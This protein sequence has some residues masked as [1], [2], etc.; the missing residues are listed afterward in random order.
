MPKLKQIPGG[1]TY[2]I[3]YLTLLFVLPIVAT[4][5]AVHYGYVTPDVT[6]TATVDLTTPLDWLAKG[7]V[8][9]FLLWTALQIVRVTGVGFW[10]RVADV[11][12]EIADNYQR[13]R[14]ETIQSAADA[15]EEATDQTDE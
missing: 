15:L 2:A 3:A 1:T 14:R 5:A 10:A 4:I 7:L 9:V 8:V 12:A 6:V 11:A 13:Q